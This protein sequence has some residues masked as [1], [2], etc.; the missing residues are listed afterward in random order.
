MHVR[1][2]WFFSSWVRVKEPFGRT[3]AHLAHAYPRVGPP[4]LLPVDVTAGIRRWLRMAHHRS[5]G[6]TLQG[7][8]SAVSKPN[9]ASKYALESFRRDLQNAFLCTVL[10][11]NPKKQEN[12]GQ[13][14]TW[15]NSGEKWP[16]EAHKQP[17]LA[18][19][20]YLRARS[21]GCFL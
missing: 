2:C 7:S 3:R 21:E 16:G 15:T 4:P 12:H 20:Y 14:R 10:E 11:S 5:I 8:F 19:Q 18:T 6:Q 1:F 13:K 9:F 17:P